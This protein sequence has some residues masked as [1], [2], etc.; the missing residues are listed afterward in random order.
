VVIDLIIENGLVID[1]SGQPE[2]RRDILIS[3]DRV[4]DIVES[5]P[6]IPAKDRLDATGQIVAPG[7]IDIHTHLDAQ[8]FWDPFCTPSCFYGITSVVAGNCG[9]STA[10]LRADDDGYIRRMLAEVEAIPVESLEEGANWQGRDFSEF[11]AQVEEANPALNIGF[12]AGH[13]AL[14]RMVLGNDHANPRPSDDA[15]DAM[16]DALEDALRAGAIGFSSSWNSIHVDGEGAPV[17]SRF[18]TREEVLSLCETLSRAPGS[19]LEFIPT[20]GNFED[21]HIELMIQM[22]LT[23]N[24]PLNWNV[25]IPKRREIVERQLE[26]STRADAE[27]ACI[28]ALTYPGATVLRASSKSVFFRTLP[29]WNAL[30]EMP[31]TEAGRRLR[32]QSFRDGLRTGVLT[33]QPHILSIL[34]GFVVADTH[35]EETSCFSGISLESVG[36]EVGGDALDGLFHVWEADDLKTGFCPEPMANSERSWEIRLETLT[37]PRVLVGASDAGAHLDALSTFDYPATLLELVRTRS[38][39][40]LP[41]AIEKLTKVPADFYGLKKRGTLEVGNF[42]DVVIFDPAVVEPGL[43]GWRDDLPGGAGRIFKKPLGI[44]HVI[45]NGTPVVSGGELTGR[46]PGMLLRRVG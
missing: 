10:P 12:L 27:G 43:L 15:I 19:Q 46:R 11:L 25:L 3:G 32:D 34:E 23:A 22:S 2:Q 14:R 20:V 21:H 26:A 31:A 24:A 40:S 8:V 5:P 33:Q 6:H 35:S 44:H 1:G 4:V 29:G 45:V 13:S 41:L 28:K 17:P 39:L 38:V 7:F 42:A 16:R 9:F 37:D 36:S 18:S 30:F